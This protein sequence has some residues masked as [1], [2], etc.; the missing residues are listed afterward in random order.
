MLQSRKVKAPEISVNLEISEQ[1]SL[2]CVPCMWKWKQIGDVTGFEWCWTEGDRPPLRVP[3]WGNLHQWSDNYS[4]SIYHY[5]KI[6]GFGTWWVNG[7]WLTQG[8][9]SV[10]ISVFVINDKILSVY[11]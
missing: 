2:Q 1:K 5:L 7:R 4:Y 8:S 10:C 11:Q 3:P 9:H 6:C